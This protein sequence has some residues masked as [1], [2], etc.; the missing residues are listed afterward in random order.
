MRPRDK[1]VWGGMHLFTKEQEQFS[2][3]LESRVKAEHGESRRSSFSD[4]SSVRKT[5]SSESLVLCKP[6][7]S[8]QPGLPNSTSHYLSP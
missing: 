6:E 5:Q 1:W 3:G 2:K 7:V 4:G 8:Q